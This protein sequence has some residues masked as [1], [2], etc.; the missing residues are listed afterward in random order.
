MS[1]SVL[2]DIRKIYAGLNADEI[3]GAAHRDLNVGLMAATDEG[4]LQMEYFLAPAWL[5]P[6]VRAEALR[7]F[8]PV[9][10]NSTNLF[11]FVLTEPGI[12]PPPNGYTFDPAD[13]DLLA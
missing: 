13:T 1:L 5:D 12:P 3:R 10:G 9:N 4:H 7:T 6:D 11:D 8:H 2:K